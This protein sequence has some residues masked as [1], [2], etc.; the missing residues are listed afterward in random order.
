[1]IQRKIGLAKADYAKSIENS[2]NSKSAE[3]WKSLKSLLLLNSSNASCQFDA[4]ELNQF[5]NRFDKPPTST[6]VLPEFCDSPDFFSMDDVYFVLKSTN[7]R[8]SCG[9]DNIPPKLLKAA[10]CVLT[11]PVRNIFNK[12]IK[13]GIFPDTWNSANIK[14]MPKCK[15][16]QSIRNF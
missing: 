12:S 5:Y 13:R 6:V 15:T 3:A 9:P 7:D 4:N 10:T 1:M 8:K 2:F 11:E 14:P 16:P